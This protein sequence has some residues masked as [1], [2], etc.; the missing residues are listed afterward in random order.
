MSS[1]TLDSATEPAPVWNVTLVLDAGGC[2]DTDGPADGEVGVLPCADS[3][4]VRI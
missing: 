2:G 3:S 1:G 4:I